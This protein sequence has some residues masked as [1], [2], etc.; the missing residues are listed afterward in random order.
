MG[1]KMILVGVGGYG[2]TYLNEA[3]DHPDADMELVAVV[4]PYP[5]RCAR[6]S[7]LHERGVPVYADMEDFYAG[8]KA[9]LAVISTPIFLHTRHILSA[10]SH[11]SHVLCEKPLCSDENDIEVLQKAQER[12]GKF[13]YIG[14]QWAF[15]DAVLALKDDVATGTLGALIEMKTLVL[16]PRNQD[17]FS[18]GVGWAG[19][20][21]TAGG[22]LVYDSIANN[23]AA[24]YLFNMLFIM[25]KAGE[26][27][28]PDAFD[29][30]LLR[31]NRIENFDVSKLDLTMPSGAKAY[32]IGAHPVN[33]GV[34]PVFT[35][36]FENGT[37]YYAAA[38]TESSRSLMPS[39]YT[40]YG[41]ILAVMNDGTK[42]VYGDPFAEQNRKFHLAVAD[43]AAGKRSK[44]VCSLKA[45][46]V[47]TRLINGIQKNCPIYDTKPELLRHKDGLT[48]VEGLF[49]ALVE[50]Y[51][52]PQ[53]SILKFGELS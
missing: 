28:A 35:Y 48:Y 19:K 44:G 10:L 9:D 24:H 41:K 4:E 34:E 22:D 40:E 14:Y 47:H 26:A 25:G 2:A 36:Q 3:L 17:Y 21:R 6:L 1:A 27:A 38:E 37:V 7:E 15:S 53:Q 29:A 23:S 12:A 51:H 52:N 31:A 20:I 39:E 50:L 11:G 13:V 32:F 45:A 18:R 16:R 43:A 8:N 46:A 5:E 42:Y 33:S 49:E 30:E